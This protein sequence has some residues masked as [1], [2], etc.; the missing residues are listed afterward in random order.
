MVQAVNELNYKPKMIGGAMVGLQATVF[1]HQ[2]GAKLNGI[3]NYETWVPS[4]KMMAPAAEFFKKYQARA[5]AEGVDPLGYYLGGW[6]Y[7]YIQMLGE[8]IAAPR[9]STTTSSPTT[10]A[11]PSIKTI[12]GELEYGPKGEW[13]KSGMMQVQYHGIKEGDD[14]EM[15]RHELPDRADAAGP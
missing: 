2:L 1:K 9:A 11:R 10:C 5:G 12:M 3:V 4:E 13:T 14:L 8:A 6:G 7:A 15:A